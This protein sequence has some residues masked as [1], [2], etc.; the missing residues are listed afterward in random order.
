MIC[1]QLVTQLLY[2]QLHFLTETH[3]VWYGVEVYEL[4]LSLAQWN[5]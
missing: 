2:V 4:S 5:T 1:T 3:L